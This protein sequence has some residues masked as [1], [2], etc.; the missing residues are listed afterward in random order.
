LP[1][2]PGDI[3]LGKYRITEDG[4]LGSGGFGEV[5][6][7]T[8]LPLNVTRA[9]KVL[10][11]DAPGFGKADFA[12]AQERFLNEAQLGA[13][14]NSPNPNP[15][16]LMVFETLSSEELT[17][18]VM[19]Y[20]PGKSLARRSLPLPIEDAL[21]IA[22]DV[23]LGLSALHQKNIIHRDIK[24]AN[25]LFDENGRAKLADLG[26]AQTPDDLSMR[27][28]LGKDGSPPHPGTPAY[29]SPEQ[30][31]TRGMLKSPSDIYA[32]GLVL[33]EM[34]TG[35]N[36]IYLR[37]GT[38]ARSLRMDLPVFVDDLLARMLA[39]TPKDRPWDGKET[40]ALLQQAQ[41]ELKK[42]QEEQQARLLAQKKAEAEAAEKAARIAAEKQA[43][44]E[45]EE[46][47]E[48]ARQ[49]RLIA[50]AQARAQAAEQALEQEK[51]AR[52]AAAHTVPP[53]PSTSKVPA[54]QFVLFGV[55]GLVVVFWL[56]RSFGGVP[57]SVAPTAV[58]QAA[59]PTDT[60]APGLGSTQIGADGMTLLY[61]PI[62]PFTMGSDSGTAD[63]KPAHTVTLAAFW[64]DQTEVT[65][66]M[67]AKFVAAK[68]YQTE[69]EKA[70]KSWVLNLTSKNWEETAGANWQH[71]QGPS[72]NLDGLS[73]H[74]VVQVSWNDASAYCAWADRRLPTEAEWEKAAR[75]TD[76]RTYPWGETAP[77]GSLLNFA[78]VNMAVDWADKSAN[79]GYQFTAPVGNYPKGASPYGAYDMAG[80]VWEWV[81]DWYDVYQGGDKA[82][83]SDFGVKYR[84]LRG[85]SW[86][87]N[88]NGLRVSLRNWS[89]PDFRLDLD[90]F[91]CSR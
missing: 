75:G 72:S 79:D 36:Y 11:S 64:I 31:N 13:Q 26:L 80:N 39:E 71:P 2:S 24:P 14:L 53:T 40:F 63:E 82:T 62:G 51:A 50:E 19:E 67:F 17:G 23:A 3:L 21:Q 6:R 58:A 55:V 43:Q 30:Q 32:L 46:Q 12:S 28:Q 59:A 10:R 20:A 54:W 83:S 15:R 90:G 47:R 86:V 37:P 78:D 52:R 33:F 49:A 27:S 25:I 1:F 66:A 8:Y 44:R 16:L 76:A 34:L 4:L 7:V 48:K 85:G 57:A 69:A 87:N 88:D 60:L 61:V 81:N 38:R 41:A 22:A 84:V 91:R 45:M 9:I 29:M 65:N 68:N 73:A 77:D 70:G 56:G 18:L 74:P 89:S 5:Y 42:E 35:Q